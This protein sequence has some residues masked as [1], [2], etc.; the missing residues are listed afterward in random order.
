MDLKKAQVKRHGYWHHYV[1]V[2]STTGPVVGG[3]TINPNSLTHLTVVVSAD[4]WP[5]TH[6]ISRIITGLPPTIHC[7]RSQWPRSPWPTDHV[8]RLHTSRFLSVQR[9][10]MHTQ[11]TYRNQHINC[12]LGKSL[13]FLTWFLNTLMERV[14]KRVIW[15]WKNY[16]VCF[17]LHS[18]YVDYGTY[19]HR[20]F[21]YF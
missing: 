2:R 17:L 21:I 8:Y 20:A 5:H 1:T 10:N 9:C 12:A 7:H 11:P 16:F 6:I 15:F 14:V 13:I 3:A 19:I 4:S 18:K